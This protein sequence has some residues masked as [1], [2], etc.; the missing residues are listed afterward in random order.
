MNVFLVSR[1]PEICAQ[2]LDDKRVRKM[3]LET[4]QLICTVLNKTYHE[5]VTPYESVHHNHPI[6]LWAEGLPSSLPWLYA[7]GVAYGE[8]VI[9]RDGRKHASHLVLE[10]LT[11]KWPW[12]TRYRPLS[13]DQFY[14][15]ARH[16]G[17]G[18]DFTHLPIRK[19][20]REYLNARWPTDKLKPVWTRRDP[21]SWCRY[22]G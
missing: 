1:H 19:A 16:K 22:Q 2:S 15:C 4:T 8:E 18:L 17:K 11:F 10:G 12:L 13:I 9:Y 14:N 7:L 5:R 21:P 20:Y 6:T 3:V